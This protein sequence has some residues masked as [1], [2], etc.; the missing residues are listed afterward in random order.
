MISDKTLI[1]AN[2]SPL[3]LVFI[4]DSFPPRNDSTSCLNGV[5]VN[6]LVAAYETT[7]VQPCCSKGF[8]VGSC[9]YS[10]DLRLCLRNL[11]V[12]FPD[13]RLKSLKI[14]KFLSYSI[15]CCIYVIFKKTPRNVY[16]VHS[17]PPLNLPLFALLLTIRNLFSRK[18]RRSVAYIHD[19]YP[20]IA[21]P[22]FE[23][24]LLLK[25]PIII[26]NRLYEITYNSYD[27]IICCSPSIVRSLS[28][29]YD[30]PARNLAFVHNW[31]LL[32][33]E[34][35]EV[36]GCSSVGNS[37]FNVLVIG[38]LGILH[39][40]Q[41]AARVLSILSCLEDVIV[42]VFARGSSLSDLESSIAADCRNVYFNDYVTPEHLCD[43]Y[44]SS[45]SLTFV[46]LNSHASLH[47][48]PSRLSSA[49]SMGSPI[50]FLSDS[51]SANPVSQ[52]L[53]ENNCGVCIGVDDADCDIIA[54]MH[55]LMSNYPQYS[56]NAISAYRRHMTKS[57]GLASI[58][59]LIAG[60][61]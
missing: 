32:N 54:S 8:H 17:S 19:L 10:A 46:S 9:S 28:E 2:A 36:S 55:S 60:L 59:S 16:I 44:R 50:I 45:P 37:Y 39:L 20:D 57:L 13:T 31:S 30:V 23:G 49:L 6:S 7:V 51:H 11:P 4:T 38:N 56:C 25:L 58:S 33:P 41:P 48:F 61:E 47:A 27:I 21:L 1:T 18:R 53:L 22:A 24:N 15:L 34:G 35:L 26:L 42:N 43:I 5:I 40:V 3:K 14:I 12:L 29:K 52:F